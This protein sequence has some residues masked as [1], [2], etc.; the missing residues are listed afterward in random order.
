MLIVSNLIELF[1]LPFISD[2]LNVAN[3]NHLHSLDSLANSDRNFDCAENQLAFQAEFHY[4]LNE[5]LKSYSFSDKKLCFAKALL[6][7]KEMYTTNNNSNTTYHQTVIE[8]ITEILQAMNALS[9]S[10]IDQDKILEFIQITDCAMFFKKFNDNEL[11]VYAAFHPELNASSQD[12]IEKYLQETKNLLQLFN[13]GIATINRIYKYYPSKIHAIF[14]AI[15]SVSYNLKLQILTLLQDQFSTQAKIK[16]ADLLYLESINL[17]KNFDAQEKR[18]IRK[19]ILMPLFR[20]YSLQNLLAALSKSDVA[21]EIKAMICDLVL[22]QAFSG[23]TVE[24]D[25]VINTLKNLLSCD[26]AYKPIMEPF[27]V[28]LAMRIKLN[29]A[30]CESG[31]VMLS[32]FGSPLNLVEVAKEDINLLLTIYDELNHDFDEELPLEKNGSQT[33]LASATYFFSEKPHDIA[34]NNDQFRAAIEAFMQ[35]DFR[36]LQFILSSTA[37]AL[38][39]LSGNLISRKYTFLDLGHS[40]IIALYNEITAKLSF[41]H[42]CFIN[43]TNAFKFFKQSSLIEFADISFQFCSSLSEIKMTEYLRN[44]SLLIKKIEFY[45]KF[46]QDKNYENSDN[47]IAIAPLPGYAEDLEAMNKDLVNFQTLVEKLSI[48]LISVELLNKIK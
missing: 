43:L 1:K 45:K 47:L 29:S 39:Q 40:K 36:V 37:T 2:C 25:C 30:L 28:F 24:M 19:L 9:Q 7:F 20:S 17:W 15:H 33:E 44:L 34:Q 4:Y 22:H 11:S 23:T 32:K 10:A 48:Q 21:H 35:N 8:N 38:C 42:S 31:Q 16:C 41:V 18:L 13:A 3:Q 12:I 14:E 5:I 46:I 6:I 26:T 27:A